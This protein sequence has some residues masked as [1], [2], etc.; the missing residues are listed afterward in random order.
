[1]SIPIFI[2]NLERRP[3]RLEYMAAQLNDIGIAWECIAAHDMNTVNR[4]ILAQEVAADGHVVEMGLGSQCCALTNFDI[5]RKIVDENFSAA[6]I[7][8]DDVELS[9]E[10]VPFLTSLDWLP[11]DIHLVQFEKYGKTDSYRLLGP[12][13][14][15][16]PVEGRTLHR[17]HSRTAGA[18]CYLITHEGA[19]RVLAEKPVMRMPIDHFLFSPNVSPIFHRLGV[20]VVSPALARQFEDGFVSDIEL[21][22][23]R[24]RKKLRV[25][26]GRLWQE[27]NRIPS[28]LIAIMLGARWR[29]FGYAKTRR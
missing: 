23:Q 18:A 4:D 29:S 28:Q 27:V 6:L 13:L 7:L 12:A 9:A 14:G 17:L 24:R 10:I 22:R 21:E 16:M 2:I 20:A 11:E 3:D 15:S 8:Q 19:T 25:R 1:M 5:Y 26:L